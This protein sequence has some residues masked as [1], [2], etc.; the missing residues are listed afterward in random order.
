MRAPGKPRYAERM[1]LLATLS[2]LTAHAQSAEATPEAEE[3]SEVEL[4]PLSWPSLPWP[5][6]V[7]Q[8]ATVT[9]RVRSRADGTVREIETISGGPGRLI[10][11]ARKAAMQVV[12]V[13]EAA[14]PS[15]GVWVWTATFDDALTTTYDVVDRT[16]WRPRETGGRLAVMPAGS[17]RIGGGDIEEI[18]GAG[19][20]AGRALQVLPGVQA[21]LLRSA[22]VSL[23]GAD[24]SEVLW[25]LEGVPLPSPRSV[26]TIFT[27]VPQMS[28]EAIDVRTAEVPAHIP[29]V[30]AG[31]VDMT[32]VEPDDREWDGT[33][34]MT[35]ALFQAQVA[36]PLGP[37]DRGNAVLLGVRR[38]WL[39]PSLQLLQ[40]AGV[41]QS[42]SFRTSDLVGRV[43][44]EPGPGQRIDLIVLGGST[45]NQGSATVDADPPVD[46]TNTAL[47]IL[48]HRWRVAPGVRLE[49]RL[50]A[51]REV[52]DIASE[53]DDRRDRRTRPAF[54]SMAVLGQP[55]N[56]LNGTL[57]VEIARTDLVGEG[58]LLDPRVAPPWTQVAWRRLDP[59]S[60]E[61]ATR[62]GWTETAGFG[63][64]RLKRGIWTANLA[65]RGSHFAWVDGD[66]EDA[67]AL[68]W[69]GTASMSAELQTGTRL[70]AL[71]SRGRQRPRDPIALDPIPSLKAFDLPRSWNGVIT[72]QQALG[73]SALIRIDAWGR[74]MGGLAAWEG[75]APYRT[76]FDGTER[77][78]G[79]DLL[80]A[81]RGEHW[82]GGMSGSLADSR[83]TGVDGV[84]VRPPF[85]VPW[86][87]QAHLGW[88]PEG[89][90]GW[91]FEG[92]GQ[93]RAG[94]ETVPMEAAVEE[95]EVVYTARFDERVRLGPRWRL[96]ARASRRIVIA[97]RVSLAI[98]GEALVTGGP[99]GLALT[100][101]DVGP[102]GALIPPDE[103]VVRDPRLLP[104]A[105]VR[106][107]F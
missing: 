97:D 76:R 47:G 104:W 11:A 20:D 92:R 17:W 37:R 94:V 83:R 99:V 22:A 80:L 1:L 57:G 33:V 59:P 27:R 96:A 81:V 46:T 30:V 52:Q 14:A 69:V 53:S 98:W 48:R 74:R 2:L 89:E 7:A 55:T 79:V 25:T 41:D 50:A 60:F 103:V 88:Q 105:G 5:Q 9:L 44:L 107:R 8:S 45:R 71:V 85:M 24:P 95:G 31:S 78:A 16:P 65:L 10:T 4:F 77:A 73:E 49:Q 86:S 34:E 28:I 100:G 29:G 35:P 18:S 101:A 15:E 21:P 64:A 61:L 90:D 36:T 66:N 62:T 6:G 39:E 58:N 26:G 12:L 40:I 42:W 70:S 72:V 3:A 93:V 54:R 102:D 75:S 63:S 13:N 19:G 91:R 32:L 56:L 106:A 43:R 67:G 38:S 82:L 23:H 68:A 51:T 87:A 84:S